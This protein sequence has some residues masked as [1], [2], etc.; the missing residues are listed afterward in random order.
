MSRRSASARMGIKSSATPA[1]R[2]LEGRALFRKDA[3]DIQP[4]CATAGLPIVPPAAKH[5]GIEIVQ[6]AALLPKS[7]G[8][9]HD[10]AGRG[11]LSF[12]YGLADRVGHGGRQ[13]DA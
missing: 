2:P 12:R 8:I 6:V 10:L 3:S 1:A 9:P 7:Q 13:G 5:I 4:A 11:I